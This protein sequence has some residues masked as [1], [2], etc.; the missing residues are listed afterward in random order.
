MNWSD[1][2]KA[3]DVAFLGHNQWLRRE[4]SDRSLSRFQSDRDH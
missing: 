2:T 4:Y 3:K 1:I